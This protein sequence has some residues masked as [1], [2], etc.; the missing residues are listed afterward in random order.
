MHRRPGRAAPSV[1]ASTCRIAILII[2][3]ATAVTV[4]AMLLV[5]R[6]APEGSYFTDGD[7]ASGVFGV[8]ATGFAIL[9]GLVVV[10][11]FTSYD[12]S[13]A[14]A[15]EEALVVV[16]Q[17]ETAQLL[18]AP[19]G[20]E[21]SGQLVCYARAVVHQEWPLMEDGELGV[22]VNP[23]AP[24]L[25]NTLLTVDPQTPASQAAYGK[26]L[27][28]TSDR[29]LARNDRV[30]GAAGVIPVTLW[31]VL[32]ITAAVIFWFM[33]FFADSGERPVVQATLIGGVTIV[34]TATLLLI[35]V[36]D[37]PFRPGPGGLKPAAMERSLEI[38]DEILPLIGGVDPPCD[39]L[40]VATS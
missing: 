35:N 3:A 10:L 2:V 9:L 29:E 4:T 24:E 28:Q 40:G 30:H 1:P 31:L 17:L 36:L 16:Q 5:R 20:A 22:S 11:A 38:M 23:W 13:R 6:R 26:W 19:E 21:L 34:I 18:P 7:R 37:N 25:F 39:E 12:E 14:G 8:L 27:D 15:E 33:L 32:C